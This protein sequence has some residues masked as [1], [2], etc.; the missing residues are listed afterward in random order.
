MPHLIV[1]YA[2]TSAHLPG[3][4]HAAPALPPLPGLSRLLA[5]LEPR[6]R[7]AGDAYSLSPPHE[8]AYA[9]ALGLPDGD[10]A[11]PWAAWQAG[12]TDRACAWFSP[13]H[14]QA[15]M[16]QVT[17]QPADGLELS[18][19][20]SRALLAALHPWAEEDGIALHFESATRWRAEGAVFAGLPCASLD[21]VA[22]RRVDL[23]LPDATRQ[24]QARALLRLQSEAQMLF[25][26]HPVNDARAARGL[27]LIN[28][29]WISGC[30]AWNGQ[31]SSQPAPELDERLRQPA[32][33]GDL[34]GWSRAWEQLDQSAIATL[35][36]RAA[37]GEPVRLTLCGERHAQTWASPARPANAGLW[38][39]LTGLLRPARQPDL[40]QILSEL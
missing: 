37:A 22:H 1:P 17:L 40:P 38:S 12:V 9:R 2:A 28:G 27:P 20:D 18:E 31:A 16:D 32:L 33:R 8:R 4:D 10:G 29:F 39:R 6:E 11:I 30:G 25:Y 3:S 35:L 34:A 19:A 14:W 23:W 15:G 36:E 24:P 26:S 7:D 21:R 5:L 13:C